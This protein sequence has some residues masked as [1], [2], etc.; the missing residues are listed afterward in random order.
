MQDQGGYGNSI[1]HT[2][3]GGTLVV[4]F[5]SGKAAVIGRDLVVKIA[6]RGDSSA[7]RDFEVPREEPCF[8]SQAATQFPQKIILVKPVFG[9]VE[10][11]G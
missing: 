9:P 2:R 7:A 6:Q 3:R 1:H 8:L 11:V 10:G 4:V 5:S